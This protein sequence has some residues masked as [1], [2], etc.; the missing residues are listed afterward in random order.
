MRISQ[1]LAAFREGRLTASHISKADLVKLKIGKEGLVDLAYV[2]P[3]VSIQSGVICSRGECFF[4]SYSYMN[5]GGYVRDR[6][7]I[8]R[9]VSI[10]RRV[11][12]GAGTHAMQGL[13]TSPALSN[14]SETIPYTPDQRER[15]NPKPRGEH[16]FTVLLNDV[17]IGDGVV[18]SSGVTI[19]IGAIV[20]ANAVVTRDVPPYAVV[21]GVPAKILRYRF[22][23]D[24]IHALLTSEWWECPKDFLDTLP[25]GNVLAII[26]HMGGEK[27]RSPKQAIG[28]YLLAS[29]P[30]IR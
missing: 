27:Q 17:W 25:L 22:P 11:T 7:F 1:K 28:T 9:Y 26:E 29:A 3:S 23:D 8:G 6:V 2:E 5:N 15:L 12:L 20:G 13:S 16:G 21:A 18:V 4:G 24:V 19:G 14:T 30:A 10:G